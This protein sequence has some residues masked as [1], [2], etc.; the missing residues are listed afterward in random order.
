ML[1]RAMPV[2]I[3]LTIAAVAQRPQFEVATIKPNT[4]G[5]KATGSF[6]S[7]HVHLQNVPLRLV[8]SLAYKVREDLVPGGPSWLDSANFDIEGKADGPAGADSMLLM[9]QALIEERFQLKLHR[10]TREGPVYLL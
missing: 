6:A 2:L 4:N 7:G 8:I 10:E 5:E 1:W 3:I 9:L